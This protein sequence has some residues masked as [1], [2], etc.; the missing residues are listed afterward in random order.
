M[1]EQWEGRLR[2]E[3]NLEE[4]PLKWAAAVLAVAA[5]AAEV[6]VVLAVVV[7]RFMVSEWNTRRSR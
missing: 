7:Q 4:E 3:L 2:L 1:R 6:V 5:V